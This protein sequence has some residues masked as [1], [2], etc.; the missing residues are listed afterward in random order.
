MKI[1]KI[2]IKII[3]LLTIASLCAP[4]TACNNNAQIDDRTTATTRT[5]ESEML[6]TGMSEPNQSIDPVQNVADNNVNAPQGEFYYVIYKGTP[7]ET[8]IRMDYD[9]H[10]G[11]QY[12]QQH[13]YPTAYYYEIDTLASS[14]GWKLN[15]AYSIED[16]NEDTGYTNFYTYDYGDYLVVLDVEAS[17]DIVY[18]QAWVQIEALRIS[19]VQKGDFDT[20]YFK[21]SDPNHE[22]IVFEF[23]NHLSAIEYPGLGSKWAFSYDDYVL[24]TYLFWLLPKLGEAKTE[25]VYNTLLSA[26]VNVT[27]DE[28]DATMILNLQ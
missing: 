18:S 23:G 19:Y 28:D 4:F 22:D 25:V 1:A 9:I 2:H 3:A 14:L 20:P 13:N 17:T 10:P 21:D 15:G 7:Q 11:T 26:A 6:E 24:M 12:L 27:T 8:I 5:T 16:T